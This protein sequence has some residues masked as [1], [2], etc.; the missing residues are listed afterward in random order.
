MHHVW[1]LVN[2]RRALFRYSSIDEVSLTDSCSRN[3]NDCPCPQCQARR[4][5]II[6]QKR[7]LSEQTDSVKAEI[8]T[9]ACV[10]EKLIRE[11]RRAEHNLRAEWRHFAPVRHEARKHRDLFE[12]YLR[13]WGER[14][15]LQQDVE[16]T[17]EVLCGLKSSV[18][19]LEESESNLIADHQFL[20]DMITNRSNGQRQAPSKALS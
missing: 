12:R 1:H 2:Y 6:E 19:S 8:E 16:R 5:R 14:S 13:A 3:P 7:A 9:Q 18:R 11:L 4:A 17:S 15:R 10:L 20:V